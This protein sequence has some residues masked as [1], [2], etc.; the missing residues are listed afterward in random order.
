MYNGEYMQAK[1]KEYAK[2]LEVITAPTSF[3]AISLCCPGSKRVTR[4]ARELE[5][6]Q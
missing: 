3:L 2:A 6:E 1:I 4:R 5:E